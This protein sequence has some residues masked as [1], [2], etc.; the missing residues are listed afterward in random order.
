MLHC[1]I[2]EERNTPPTTPLNG[3]CWLVGTAATGVWAGHEGHIAIRQ[4]D[5]W[6]FAAASDGVQLLNKATGQRI[7][8][9]GETWRA[10][11]APAAV[12][13]GTVIDAEA[14]AAVASLVAA[15]RSTGTLPA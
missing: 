15:L 13:G 3:Q 11:A 12:T 4:L 5:Q 1:A 14:R 10:P 8:R 7:G 2:E 9:I 6:L